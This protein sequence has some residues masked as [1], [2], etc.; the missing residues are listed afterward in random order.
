MSYSPVISYMMDRLSGF[1]TSS[2]RLQALGSDTA[3]GGQIIRFELPT[4]AL[5]DIRK[6]SL[7]V[8]CAVAGAGE[9]RLSE[10]NNIVQRVSVTIGGVE[11]NSGFN[12]YSLLKH[13]K[14][15]LMGEHACPV[16]GHPEIP[17]NKLYHT[18]KAS[19]DLSGVEDPANYR[20]EGWLGFLGECE[21]RV[22]D[23]SLMPPVQISIFLNNDFAV[24]SNSLSADTGVNFILPTGDVAGQN[25]TYTLTDIYA[26]VPVLSFSSGIYDNLVEAMMQKQGFLEIPFKNYTTFQDTANSVRFHATSA[27][28]DRLWVAPRTASYQIARVPVYVKGYEDDFGK[29]FDYQ[30]DKYVHSYYDMPLPVTDIEDVTAYRA[31]WSINSSLLPQYQMTAL[32]QITLTKESVPR[33]YQDKH[34]LGTMLSNYAASCVRLNL[35]GSEQLRLASGLDSRGIAVSGLYNIIAGNNNL[36]PITIFVESTS[37][38]RVGRN[39]Q[40]EV[41]A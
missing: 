22:L 24:V 3:V 30:N 26:T 32:D 29:I 10:I 38:L 4:N 18:T 41:L 13:V 34:T 39:Q 5:V 23:T 6:F 12:E 1:S 21:P 36:V 9:V 16:S 2:F 27:S 19:T 11:V 35:E 20:V 15:V 25:G 40:I 14:N 8:R 31:Q 17:R 7:A 28:V 33:K 37:V